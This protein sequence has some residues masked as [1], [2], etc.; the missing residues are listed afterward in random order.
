MTDRLKWLV[1]DLRQ[2]PPEQLL[3]LG[4]V[5]LV[6]LPLVLPCLLVSL[7]FAGSSQR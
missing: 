4:L 5:A 1:S 6:F 3:A 7:P 2:Y